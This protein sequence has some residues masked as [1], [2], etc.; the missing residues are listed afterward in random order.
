MREEGCSQHKNELG[1]GKMH[2]PFRALEGEGEARGTHSLGKE[3]S[4]LGALQACIP[5]IELVRSLPATPSLPRCSGPAAETT[6]R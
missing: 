3:L 2:S 1:G 4:S 6:L 5:T